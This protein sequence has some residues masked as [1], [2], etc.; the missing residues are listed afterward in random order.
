MEISR[1]VFAF[2]VTC[3]QLEIWNMTPLHLK[4]P[5]HGTSICPCDFDLPCSNRRNSVSS[6]GERIVNANRVSLRC[7]RDRQQGARGVHS[8][9]Q[10]QI[11]YI[12]PKCHHNMPEI[13]RQLAIVRIFDHRIHHKN[14]TSAMFVWQ[15]ERNFHQWGKQSDK[16]KSL[17]YKKRVVFC[18]KRLYPKE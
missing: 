15:H 9:F 14:V 3:L 18:R 5:L 17:Q 11:Y 8:K 4:W 12:A 1:L 6:R 16:N 10:P 2:K 7:L 13:P